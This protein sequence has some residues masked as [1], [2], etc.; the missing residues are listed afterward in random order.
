[1]ISG[2]PSFGLQSNF[3]HQVTPWF[4]ASLVLGA[5]FFRK[6]LSTGWE[7]QEVAGTISD[8]D[9]LYHD[10]TTEMIFILNPRVTFRLPNSSRIAPYLFTGLFLRSFKGFE[11]P[12]LG[13]VTY[14]RQPDGSHV[15]IVTGLGIRFYVQKNRAF[16][17]EIPYTYLIKSTLHRRLEF[18]FL[19]R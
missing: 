6:E 3:G 12:N 8:S 7:I 10:P 15:G 16:F 17:T 11:A 13:H 2:G 5:F 18:Y 9:E 14:S 1:M 4:E 19:R